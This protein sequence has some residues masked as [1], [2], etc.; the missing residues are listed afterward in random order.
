M[1]IATNLRKGVLEFCVLGLLV[2]RPRYGFELAQSLHG[3]GLI[4]S[5]GTLSNRRVFAQLGDHIPDGI[6]L[7]AEGA[8][9]AASPY[10]GQVIRVREG[11]AIVDS[12]T[13]DGAKPYAC[14]L[15]GADG[16]DLYICCASDH[17]PAVTVKERAGRIDVARVAV[18]GAGRP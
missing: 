17:D 14:M 7:D 6:C 12:V 5:D 16:R 15:G 3:A 8:I 10:A 4:A 18:P 1:R 9:W 2:G 13:I 11:G